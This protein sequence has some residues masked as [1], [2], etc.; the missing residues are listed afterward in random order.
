MEMQ[1][2][3]P[4]HEHEQSAAL[5][6]IE[7]HGRQKVRRTECDGPFELSAG[8]GLLSRGLATGVPSALSGLTTVFGMGTGVALTLESPAKSDVHQTNNNNNSR[9]R[10]VDRGV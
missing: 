2:A 9:S 8:D 1:E 3:G 7:W 10:V 5:P 6:C 4:G